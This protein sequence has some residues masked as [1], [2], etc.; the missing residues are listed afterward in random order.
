MDRDGRQ[1]LGRERGDEGAP[2]PQRDEDCAAGPHRRVQRQEIGRDADRKRRTAV[3]AGQHAEHDRGRQ[4][5]ER[6]LPAQQLAGREAAPRI[7][8]QRDGARD[9]QRD[10]EPAEPSRQRAGHQVVGQDREYR[11]RGQHWS[12]DRD[13]P[14]RR[15]AHQEIGHRGREEG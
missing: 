2:L 3:D 13:V 9:R 1:A 7:A 6:V 12:H 8:R 10:A 11:A 4:R 15:R 5:A 14:A